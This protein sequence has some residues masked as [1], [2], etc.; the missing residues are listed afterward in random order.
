MSVVNEL[1]T[2]SNETV[3]T[4]SN[5]ASAVGVH[6]SVKNY[7]NR[8]Y[9]E[10]CAKEVQWPFLRANNSNI[11]EPFAGNVSVDISAGTRW[12]L[13]KSGSTSTSTDYAKIDWE[14]F[15]ITTQ[16]VPGATTPY[17]QKNLKYISHQEWNR[18]FQ[19]A[20]NS[21][22]SSEQN[23]SEPSF[24]FPSLDGRYFGVSGLPDKTYKV[25][26]NAWVQPTQLST[27][28]DEIAIPD[29]WKPVLLDRASYFLHM[30]KKEFQEATLAERS[31]NR[32]LALMRRTLIG[33][34][35]DRMLD[36]RR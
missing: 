35:S 4:S 15:Y 16:D 26:F 24:V 8:A 6:S 27:Y 10:I 31:Y 3:L 23:Y 32:G 5:F 7:V 25:Y 13:L 12:Y 17:V 36:D 22:A 14:S 18:L 2:D 9:L 19:A 20:E 21:D 28:N 33:R 29:M 34:Q 1:L 30:F 11:N